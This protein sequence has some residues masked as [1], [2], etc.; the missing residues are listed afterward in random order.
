VTATAAS[1]QQNEQAGA[2]EKL[3]GATAKLIITTSTTRAQHV[4]LAGLPPTRRAATFSLPFH[5]L[6][7]TFSLP[8]HY[9]LT[10]IVTATTDGAV[11][12][13]TTHTPT[14]PPSLRCEE[15]SASLPCAPN[16]TTRPPSRHVFWPPR[17][18]DHRPSLSYAKPQAGF[19]DAPAPSTRASD[20]GRH[21]STQ[22]LP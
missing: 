14:G 3:R 7:T 22:L 13:H 18:D 8:F 12:T 15:G 1:A 19:H 2:T 6:F 20:R 17:P 16:S 11:T 5:Y 21:G 4:H 10:T 9:L